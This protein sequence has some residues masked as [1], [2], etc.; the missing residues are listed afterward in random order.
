MLLQTS[1]RRSARLIAKRKRV[2]SDPLGE[3]LAALPPE[4]VARIIPF[5]APAGV[6]DLEHV[7]GEETLPWYDTLNMPG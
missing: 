5:T 7:Q 3:H 2:E 4:L 6:L 1:L